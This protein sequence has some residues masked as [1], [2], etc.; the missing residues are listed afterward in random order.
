[1]TLASMARVLRSMSSLMGMFKW[2]PG[3][4]STDGVDRAL[5]WH[6]TTSQPACQQ[7]PEPFCR[8]RWSVGL[9]SMEILWVWL[10]VRIERERLR[11]PCPLLSRVGQGRWGSSTFFSPGYLMRGGLEPFAGRPLNLDLPI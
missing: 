2:N 5:M 11:C 6:S 8:L 10:E 4:S 7:M 1:M 3:L 9:S